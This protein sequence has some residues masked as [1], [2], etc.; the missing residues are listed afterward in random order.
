MSASATASRPLRAPLPPEA[1]QLRLQF[2][3]YL[4]VVSRLTLLTLCSSEAGAK[5]AMIE[6]PTKKTLSMS[7]LVMSRDW[8]V[9]SATEAATWL[10][11]RTAI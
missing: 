11:R 5:G 1:A 4:V 7:A 3:V 8:A 10:V 9:K 6:G 2:T